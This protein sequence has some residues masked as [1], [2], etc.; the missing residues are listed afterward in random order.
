MVNLDI[1]NIRVRSTCVFCNNHNETT[2]HVFVHC[3]ALKPICIFYKDCFS[4]EGKPTSLRSWWTVWTKKRVRCRN[5]LL[6][7]AYDQD[8]K[9]QPSPCRLGRV[10]SRTAVGE[11][12]TRHNPVFWRVL[13]RSDLNRSQLDRADRINSVLLVDSGN[14]SR[15]VC[16]ISELRSVK[17]RKNLP[18]LSFTALAR[19]HRF[20]PLP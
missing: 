12:R 10:V 15:V 17:K 3:C 11:T 4:I 20:L 18:E 16:S 2:L 13:K 6:G 5:S 7:H 19:R 1:K 9:Y 8:S 14:L